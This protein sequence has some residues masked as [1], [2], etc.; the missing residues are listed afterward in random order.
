MHEKA[1]QV[2]LESFEKSIDGLAEILASRINESARP[3]RERNKKRWE[4]FAK[5]CRVPVVGEIYF[6]SM[7]GAPKGL[8]SEPDRHQIP[9]FQKDVATIEEFARELEEMKA[10]D[11]ERYGDEIVQPNNSGDPAGYYTP[12]YATRRACYEILHVTPFI[13]DKWDFTSLAGVEKTSI[14]IYVMDSDTKEVLPLNDCV[15][16]WSAENGPR[17]HRKTQSKPPKIDSRGLGMVL[18]ERGIFE[19]FKG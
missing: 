11:L 17:Y 16:S 5:K 7:H 3:V 14:G 13:P 4:D 18:N 15:W 6:K 8:E 10:E 2:N 12:D 19:T 9:H 1:G